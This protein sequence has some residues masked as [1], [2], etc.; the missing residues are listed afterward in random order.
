MTMP[1]NENPSSPGVVGNPSPPDSSGEGNSNPA[2]NNLLGVIPQQFHSQVTPHLQQWDKNYSA[3][4]QKVHSEYAGYK[5]F[6]DAEVLPEQIN[7]ALLIMD[8]LEE[9]P[10]KFAETMIQHYGLQ[11]VPGQGQNGVPQ[12]EGAE[13][14]YNGNPPFELGNDP[15]FQRY[16][17]MTENMA[18]M[19]VQQQQQMME[20]EEDARLE[21]DLAAARET[22]G[23]FDEDFVL[24]QMY[25]HGLDVNKAVEAWKQYNQNIITNYRSPG[26]KAPIISGGG[27]GVPSQVTSVRG[28]SGPDRRKLVADILQRANQQG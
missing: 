15:R 27:G 11:F 22:H 14:E 13:P 18:Q 9:D 12:Q 26:S 8:A 19:L 5:P 4:I 1:S 16:S 7:N 3:G 21:S 20:A 6:K 24:Q 17:Q 2:W 10:Q 28:L 23:D 25:F